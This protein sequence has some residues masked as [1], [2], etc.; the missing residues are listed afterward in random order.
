MPRHVGEQ[1]DLAD[2]RE[3]H[4]ERARHQHGAAGSVLVPRSLIVPLTGLRKVELLTHVPR[5]M[6]SNV[7]IPAAGRG[8][9]RA[10]P[11]SRVAAEPAHSRAS[12]SSSVIAR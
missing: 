8:R 11:A 7:G 4:D 10:R 1:L 3:R 6:R 9:G 2:A 5:G 12:A